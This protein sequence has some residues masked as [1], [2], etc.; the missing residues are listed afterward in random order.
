MRY[1]SKVYLHLHV[2]KYWCSSSM[3]MLARSSNY[4]IV[5][6]SVS[7]FW[8]VAKCLWWIPMWISC[9]NR[10]QSYMKFL[11]GIYSVSIFQSV[12]V[13]KPVRV[14]KEN[15]VPFVHGYIF[16]L[17]LP[18]KY[19]LQAGNMFKQKLYMWMLEVPGCFTRFA[20]FFFLVISHL[21]VT[22]T[23]PFFEL[24]QIGNDKEYN[25]LQ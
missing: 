3:W 24:L 15:E 1:C 13:W 2:F 14:K 21:Y 23:F 16:F 17:Y 7:L 8:V 4:V 11:C 20:S 6:Y 19:K 18:W 10:V 25:R 5:C 9:W 12:H 22:Y